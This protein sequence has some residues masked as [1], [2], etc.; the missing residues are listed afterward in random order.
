[1]NKLILNGKEVWLNR[2]E[3]YAL[4]CAVGLVD[5]GKVGGI[6]G[7]NRGDVVKALDTLREKLLSTVKELQQ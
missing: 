6:A 7:K 3:A 4:V 5:P 2:S 1:M